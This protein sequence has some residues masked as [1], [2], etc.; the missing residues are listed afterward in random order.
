MSRDRGKLR[1]RRD[2]ES[3]VRKQKTNK[4][5]VEKRDETVAEKQIKEAT[6]KRLKALNEEIM[7]HTNKARGESI[8]RVPEKTKE[9]Y[10]KIEKYLLQ[11]QDKYLGLIRDVL[12]RHPKTKK[13]RERALDSA[14]RKLDEI[15]AKHSLETK[16]YQEMIVD[17]LKSLA[18]PKGELT[19][20]KV[21]VLNSIIDHLNTFYSKDIRF[22]ELI[23][24]IKNGD[25]NKKDWDT[26]CEN[27][28]K[29]KY[30]EKVLSPGDQVRLSATAF[31]IKLMN[32]RQKYKT[33]IQYY[34]WL[35]RN[36]GMQESEASKQAVDFAK[37]LGSA[38]VL[39]LTQ[40][41]ELIKQINPK[42]QLTSKDEK[43][44]LE[45][46][47][48]AERVTKKMLRKL[49]SAKYINAAERFLNFKT[50]PAM[51]LAVF[52]VLGSV[53]NMLANLKPTKESKF[54]PL[55]WLSK[56]QG[57]MAFGSALAG[58]HFTKKFAR[59]TPGYS[60][61]TLISKLTEKHLPERKSPFGETEKAKK[62]E[63]N[64][65]EMAMIMKN[66]P[67]MHDW[68]MNHGGYKDLNAFYWEEL[69][70]PKGKQPKKPIIERLK[71]VQD[72]TKNSDGKKALKRAIS[73]YGKNNVSM[74]IAKLTKASNVLGIE[75][76]STLTAKR[77]PNN[78][79]YYDYLQSKLG[80]PSKTK[81]T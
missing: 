53:S 64:F 36:K 20:E 27:I 70:R 39:G 45:N 49:N 19:P 65:H 48:S 46:Q 63:R 55:R 57:M 10:K 50:L 31:F 30:I 52:G 21:A 17:A 22:V 74:F 81:K 29:Q 58:A 40:V 44:L 26:I 18:G 37:S 14:R 43:E 71:A 4:E 11:K 5:A 61:G 38:G 72:K 6:R 33:V 51:L 24:R 42:L 62:Y 25:I 66:Y 3:E 8:D 16:K 47:K 68:L 32:P 7:M 15:I 79:T 69:S 23:D 35:K 80:L 56:P 41:R 59:G 67:L 78:K 12:F 1:D 75:D 13:G 9:A 73:R 2:L 28:Y 77:L 60:S 76:K 54:N 34:N